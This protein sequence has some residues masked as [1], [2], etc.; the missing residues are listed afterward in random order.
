MEVQARNTLPRLPLAEAV[1]TQWRWVADSGSLDQIFDNNR[2]RCYEAHQQRLKKEKRRIQLE[3][4]E[5]A[6]RLSRSPTKKTT[7]FSG[8]FLNVAVAIR[9]DVH[10]RVH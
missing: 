4:D 7:G 1:L 5:N 3:T 10:F 6:A 9:A 2:G 8:W